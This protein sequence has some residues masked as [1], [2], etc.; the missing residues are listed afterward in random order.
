MTECAGKC[1]TQ[2]MNEGDMCSG[3]RAGA[4]ELHRVRVEAL[5]EEITL[6]KRAR[7]IAQARLEEI[8]N[9]LQKPSRDLSPRVP[10][11]TV[12]MMHTVLEARAS[13]EEE[14]IRLWVEGTSRH[15][16][17]LCPPS[18]VQCVPDRSCCYPSLKR[19]VQERLS[20]VKQPL[21]EQIRL[22]EEWSK[23]ADDYR[24]QRGL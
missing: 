23:K 7:I 11:E 21:V 17:V 13:T 1:T 4:R 15:R 24:R 14:Q 10:R 5:E 16:P 22:N 12:I 18:G 19:D 20:Y 2:V 8:R 6:E 9:V 3:C